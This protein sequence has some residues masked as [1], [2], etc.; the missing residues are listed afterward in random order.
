M[1]GWLGHWIVAWGA[2]YAD[3]AALRTSVGF[4]HVAGLLVGGG[5]AIVADRATLAAWRRDAAGRLA[6]ARAFH[7]SHV[8]VIAG[9]FIVSVSGVLLAAADLDTYLHSWVFW[10]KMALVAVL[11]ANGGL[12]VSAGRRALTGA[13]EAW[14]ALRYGSMASLILWLVITLLGAALPNV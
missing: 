6:Q 2:A 8:A 1:P 7:A 11:I 5:T 4:A 3:S 13:D 14:T 12:L 9:L 10:M